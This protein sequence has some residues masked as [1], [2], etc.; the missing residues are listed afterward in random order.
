MVLLAQG[1]VQ[2]QTVYE[3]NVALGVGELDLRDM[4]FSSAVER[5]ACVGTA[6][7]AGSNS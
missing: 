3:D 1:M 4:T 5:P 2:S 7:S 6:T